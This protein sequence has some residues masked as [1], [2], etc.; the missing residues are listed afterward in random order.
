MADNMADN[1]SNYRDESY[2]V[3]CVE[4]EDAKQIYY[5]HISSIQELCKTHYDSREIERSFVPSW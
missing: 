1:P 2:T 3:R 5:V 4:E